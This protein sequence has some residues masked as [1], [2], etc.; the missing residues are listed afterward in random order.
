[1]ILLNDDERRRFFQKFKF[2]IPLNFS[3]LVIGLCGPN[4]Q[5]I[6][7]STFVGNFAGSFAIDNDGDYWASGKIVT[8]HGK[9]GFSSGDVVGCG[10]SV[11]SF[12]RQIFFTKNGE[13]W[14]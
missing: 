7:S 1:M 12:Q 5:S 6:Q 2:K 13:F 9:G 14:G 4:Y 3:R 10:L 11:T 8:G